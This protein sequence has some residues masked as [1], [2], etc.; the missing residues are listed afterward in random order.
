MYFITSWHKHYMYTI[1]LR[2]T[3]RD[4]R[5]SISIHMNIIVAKTHVKLAR[6]SLTTAIMYTN[7]DFFNCAKMAADIIVL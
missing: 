3:K 4:K 1:E 2:Y 5:K 7:M 6:T